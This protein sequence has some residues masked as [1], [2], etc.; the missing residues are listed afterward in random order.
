MIH[1][2]HK[3]PLPRSGRFTNILVVVCA[4]TRF[5]LYIPVSTVTADETLRVLIARVFSIFG[6]PVAVISDNGPA[7]RSELMQHAA[8][9][10]GFRHIPIMPYNAAA[11]GIAEASV[12]RIKLLLDRHTEGYEEWH[13]LLP[14]AQLLLNTQRHSSHGVSPHMALFGY[15]P[16]RMEQL[17]NPALLDAT[18]SGSEWLSEVR[19]K[20]LALHEDLR[21]QSDQIKEERAAIANERQRS[22][23]DHRS[24]KIV[25][26]G[27]VRILRG[28]EQEAAY[29]RKHGHG[30]PW[31]Y[32]YKVLDVRPHAVLLEVPKDGSVPAIS[33]WQLIR[34]C[35]PATVEVRQPGP[36]DPK[37]SEDGV[38]VPGATAPAAAPAAEEYGDEAYEIDKVLRAEKVGG[39]YMIWV[40]WRGYVDPTPVPRAQLVAE[41]AN[42][43]LLREVEEAVERYKTE[44]RLELD[45]S[46]EPDT[47][48][49]VAVELG[50][51]RVRRPPVRYTPS[52]VSLVAQLEASDASL[53]SALH[54]LADR[55][56]GACETF[57]M[58]LASLWPHAPT[59]V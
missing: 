5:T 52:H 25:V 7:F 20:L 28:S 55:A 44:K 18:G 38:C 14:L 29:L 36:L 23:L 34:R 21:R 41:S 26:G 17:E 42:E 53:V 37:F 2:D 46:D 30:V 16:V 54:V 47:Q 50:Q 12:K 22:E 1:I 49:P 51:K 15:E 4:L 10:Y 45:D 11:N 57:L 27:W 24:G 9:F 33:E 59:A 3:G 13:K 35:E 43:E 6:Y 32:R 58:G 8:K 31:K 40:K 48:P 56:A 19:S 39:R